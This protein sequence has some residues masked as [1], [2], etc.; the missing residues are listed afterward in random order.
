MTAPRDSF[1]HA[2]KQQSN[3][4]VG[5][6]INDHRRFPAAWEET[7]QDDCPDQRQSEIVRQ[8]FGAR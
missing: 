2:E 3:C 8:E 1:A 5:E 4:H 6:I 7:R